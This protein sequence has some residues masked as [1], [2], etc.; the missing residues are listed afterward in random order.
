MRA[1][2]VLT[3]L[4]LAIMQFSYFFVLLINVTS[5]YITYMVIVLSWMFGT[6]L[7]LF[8]TRLNAFYALAGGVLAYYSIFLLVVNDP[9][10]PAML[11]TAGLGVAVTGLWAGR[12]FVVL[13]PLFESPDR[14]F[15]YE[16]NGFLVGIIAVF[17]GFTLAGQIFLIW[18]P[19]LSVT[20]LLAHMAWL[21]ARHRYPSLRLFGLAAARKAVPSN[22]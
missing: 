3:G 13:Q 21:G 20:L 9:L 8:W 17:L 12:F 4:H 5:T 22:E 15:F 11:P 7:G 19:G 10:S 1:F 6:L 18:V 2:A 14:L 16:N